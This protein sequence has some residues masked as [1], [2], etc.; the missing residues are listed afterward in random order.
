MN[1]MIC[2]EFIK[3][4]TIIQHLRHR[5][6]YR[7]F[8]RFIVYFELVL[9]KTMN[10]IHSILLLMGIL[11]FNHTTSQVPNKQQAPKPTDK[12][13][14]W[15]N[16]EGDLV[17]VQ[18]N[19]YNILIKKKELAEYTYRIMDIVKFRLKDKLSFKPTILELR[20]R[21]KSDKVLNSN[22]KTTHVLQL[23]YYGSNSYGALE[24]GLK[25]IGINPTVMK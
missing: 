5:I 16:G 19:N 8:I 14:Y 3:K 22:E 4:N 18:F 2:D 1:H 24:E 7:M 10:K 17:K 6:M 15:E 12:E 21:V 20:E 23:F 11:F 25:M 9:Q 13:F